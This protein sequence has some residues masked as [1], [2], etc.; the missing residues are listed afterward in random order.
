MKDRGFALIVV[1]LV[2]FAA[3]AL[4]ALVHVQI[5]TLLGTSGRVEGRMHSLL[6]AEN[7]I[8]WAKSVLAAADSGDLSANLEDYSACPASAEWRN[9]VPFETAKRRPAEELE[10]GCVAGVPRIGDRVL[11]PA[12]VSSGD[13]TILVRFS[14]DP[15]EPSDSDREPIVV[16]RSMG[17]VPLGPAAERET[18]FANQ[19]SLVEAHLRRRRPFPVLGAITMLGP[20]GDFVWEGVEFGID[21]GELAGVA[22]L[23]HPSGGLS[24]D[25]EASLGAEGNSRIAGAPPIREVDESGW[26]HGDASELVTTGLAT[27]L[28][29]RLAAR[30]ALCP[31][32]DGDAA[33]HV[34]PNGGVIT[35]PL[36]GLVVAA[37]DLTLEEG[38]GVEG[39]LVHLGGGQLRLEGRTGITGALWVASLQERDGGTSVERIRLSISG[40]TRVNHDADWVRVGLSLLPPEQLLW[41]ILFP[42]MAL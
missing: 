33:P 13:G 36:R 34:F 29:E 31:P 18:G 22:V 32:I 27:R 37:G 21:G 25:L 30:A 20:G 40:R 11:W 16:V 8:E 6:L 3:G 4:V 23:S 42:E 10:P 7:G 35:E 12:H 41:R 38:S 1:L 14:P 26:N 28:M 17:I 15:R 19:V 39:V 24:A 2:A 9:P 5:V